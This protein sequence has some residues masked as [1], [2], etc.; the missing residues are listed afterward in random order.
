MAFKHGKDTKVFL[1]SSEI[2][3]YLNSADA[4]RTADVAESTVFVNSSK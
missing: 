2:S 1:N 3:S 4:T